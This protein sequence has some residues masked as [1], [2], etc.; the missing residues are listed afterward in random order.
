V[1][2]AAHNPRVGE[3]QR[4]SHALARWIRGDIGILVRGMRERLALVVVIRAT[5]L[6]DRRRQRR[7]HVLLLLLLERIQRSHTGERQRA[8][9]A[10]RTCAV[11]FTDLLIVGGRVVV[12]GTRE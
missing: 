4:I 8:V 3:R 6:S 12:L 5:H 9:A 11:W 2:A 1:S 7:T 10:G